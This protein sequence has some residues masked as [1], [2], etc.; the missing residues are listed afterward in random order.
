MAELSEEEKKRI[1]GDRYKAPDPNAPQP[2]IR[3]TL[4]GRFLSLF[5]RR[6]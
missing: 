2:E 1:L 6:R 5:R 3:P 4:F